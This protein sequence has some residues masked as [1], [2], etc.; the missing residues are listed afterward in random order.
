[1]QHPLAAAFSILIALESGHRCSW[2]VSSYT[3]PSLDCE[4]CLRQWDT[5]KYDTSRG[6]GNACALGTLSSGDNCYEEA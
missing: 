3:D 4:L 6:P 1:M 5:I 2:V